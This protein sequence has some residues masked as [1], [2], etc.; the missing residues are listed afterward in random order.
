MTMCSSGWPCYFFQSV[1]AQTQYSII[2]LQLD[3]MYTVHQ[4]KIILRPIK[5]R[6]KGMCSQAIYVDNELHTM[7]HANSCRT[8]VCNLNTQ[9]WLYDLHNILKECCYQYFCLESISNVFF[10]GIMRS[11]AS[12]YM[13]Q[14]VWSLAHA[15]CSVIAWDWHIGLALLCS[16]SGSLEYPTKSFTCID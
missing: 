3:I 11:V 10:C 4:S 12:S 6:N 2:W 5:L 9:L 16:C 1:P 15:P 14:W 13:Q 8:C 7:E